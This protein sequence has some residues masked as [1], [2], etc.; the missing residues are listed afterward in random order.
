MVGCEKDKG[1][2]ESNVTTAS[3]APTAVPT[4][5]PAVVDFSLKT[6]D[7]ETVF[8]N[9]KVQGRTCVLEYK[10]DKDTVEKGIALDYTASAVEFNVCCE[11]DVTANIYVNA[12]AIDTNR[13]PV[14]FINVYV[15]GVLQG[16]RSEYALRGSNEVVLA[17][18]L[19]KGTH[20]ILI[21]RQNE[22]EYGELYLNSVSFSGEF[23]ARPQNSN[24]YIE[25]IGD[26]ITTGYGNLYPNNTG[27]AKDPTRNPRSSYYQDGTRAYACLAMKALGADYSIV[28]QQ[29]IGASV[30]WQ[31]HTMLRTYE[32]ACFQN[33][34][35][36]AWNFER[37]PDL[38]II[39]LGTNDI[40]CGKAASNTAIQEGFVSF[41]ELV[42]KNNPDAKILWVY[43]AMDIS[44]TPIIEAAVNE[45]GGEA[46]GIYSYT[47][48][49]PN[50]EGG[51]GHP[52]VSAHEENANRLVKKVQEILGL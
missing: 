24:L 25:V 40:S 49:V 17:K 2:A 46:A 26:S 6:M 7:A 16:V 20:T 52:V 5:D 51:V 48:F 29:G 33:A 35:N 15:D 47:G 10:N 42:R 50:G 3:P 1:E 44:A 45:A 27:G 39:N 11:G 8:Q 12:R 23:D 30:G 36:E 43:G 32:K 22:A 38:V 37:Q 34:R 21:E 14:L 18:G 9:A 13:R 41:I 4:K 31:P 28:A 19:S